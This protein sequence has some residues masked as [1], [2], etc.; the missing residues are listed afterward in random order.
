MLN[1]PGVVVLDRSRTIWNCIY[2][3]CVLHTDSS[4]IWMLNA[5]TI[6]A[7]SRYTWYTTRDLKLS[8]VD[9]GDG[10]PLVVVVPTLIGE[11]I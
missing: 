2:T 1:L 10:T 11:L 4:S 5:V 3:I 9:G 6:L 7:S 8:K